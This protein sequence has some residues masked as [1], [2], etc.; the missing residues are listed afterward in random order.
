MTADH[1]QSAPDSPARWSLRL[2]RAGVAVLLGG[3]LVAGVVYWQGTRAPDLSDDPAM[4][5]FNRARER[6]MAIL[7]GKMGTLIEDGLDDL[8]RPGTQAALIAGGTVIV[9]A[10]CFYFARLSGNEGPRA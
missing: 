4:L 6:Q 9:A 3:S 5:G 2:R 1:P 10:G 7:Y 8:K